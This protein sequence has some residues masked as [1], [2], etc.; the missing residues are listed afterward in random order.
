M[1]LS[2]AEVLTRRALDDEVIRSLLPSPVLQVEG[3][4]SL[5]NVHA[6][7]PA[8]A[9]EGAAGKILFYV[10]HYRFPV[11]VGPGRTTDGATA[12]FDASVH[13][14]PYTPPLAHITSQ[15]LPWS[16]HVLPTTGLVCQGLA[17]LNRRGRMLLAHAIIHVARLLNCDEKDRERDYVGYNGPAIRYWRE[18]MQCRPLTPG[19][20]YPVP[21]VAVTHGI[22]AAAPGEAGFRLLDDPDIDLD[23]ADAGFRV[24]EPDDAG[25]VVLGS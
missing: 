10:A 14:Y 11:L 24:V 12:L 6:A 23:D 20:K 13:E 5:K 17:W 22:S 18:T 2:Y 9:A 19:L 1:D 8:T 15:P 21:S 16:P 25:F 7:R 3:F 4:T